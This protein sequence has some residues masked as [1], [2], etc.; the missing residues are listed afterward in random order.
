MKLTPRVLRF[1]AAYTR[2][3][4]PAFTNATEAA[5]VA[6]Y[7]G[8]TARQQGARLLSNVSIRAAIEQA[9]KK[10][11]V[12]PEVVLAELLRIATVDIGEAFNE[13]GSLK[14]LREMSADVRRAISSIEVETFDGDA[15]D[16]PFTKGAVSK[17]K[18]WDKTRGLEMLGRHLKMFTDKIEHSGSV[19]LAELVPKRKAAE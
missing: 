11:G 7:S 5:R 15:D 6:G 12:T 8:K 2:P 9:T 1:V 16:G 18:F 17:V 13:D 19:T 10:A 4:T 14:P 3:G